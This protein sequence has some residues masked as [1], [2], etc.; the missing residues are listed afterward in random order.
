M[1]KMNQITDKTPAYEIGLIERACAATTKVTGLEF[2]FQVEPL[3]GLTGAVHDKVFV[4]RKGVQ[5]AQ[6]R[7]LVREPLNPATAQAAALGTRLQKKKLLFV[8]RHVPKTTAEQ[9][10]AEGFQFIDTAAN[11]YLEVA[12]LYVFIAGGLAPREEQQEKTR[13]RKPRAFTTA[14]L[15]VLFVLLCDPAFAGGIGTLRDI[16]KRAGVALG[17]VHQ[18]VED[19]K[20][21]GYLAVLPG[22]DQRLRDREKLTHRWA[23]HYPLQLRPKLKPRRFMAA[24]KDWWRN[25]DI[26]KY[27]G[28]WGGETAA[29]LL[30]KHL[31]PEI[32]T[33][34]ATAMPA[35]LIAE[36]RMRPDPRGNVEIL[37]KF[38]HFNDPEYPA[39]VPPLLAYADLLLTGDG[40][41][42]EAAAHLQERY[43]ARF[44]DQD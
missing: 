10:R 43:L 33:I 14:G 13:L 25:L 23:D 21:F 34:Y 16:G 36:H 29:A 3:G 12:G 44:V 2:Q 24:D 1:P 41:N 8:A 38:W 18:V 4:L 11:A 40:R 37:E 9:L 7:V 17:T 32:A 26:T 35:Q 28:C 30:G 20:G 31:R 42:I 22:G 27:G 39:I 6:Y 5:A 15:K 19:L